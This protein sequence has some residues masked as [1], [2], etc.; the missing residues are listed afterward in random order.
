MTGAGAPGAAGIIKCLLQ[1]ASINLIVADTDEDAIGKHLHPNFIQIPKAAD[2][3]FTEA[4][5]DACKRHQVNVVLPLVTK[6]LFPFAANKNLFESAGI[7]VIVSSQEAIAI[8]NDKS[9]CYKFL[10][11]KGIT[12][13]D[14]RIVN[15]VS[16]FQ[17]AV[18]E[19]GY[20]QKP[21]CFKPSISNGSRGFRIIT[22]DIDESD[23]LFNQKPNNSIC[24]YADITRILSQRPFPEL[25]VSE[26]LPG[27]EFSVDC[28]AN[29][30]EPFLVL[31]RLR[32]KMINGISVK[33]QFIKNE[34]II[35]YCN[36]I[37]QLTGLH[38]N[39]GIQ[40][41]QSASGEFLLL[42][43]NPRVQGTIVAALGAGVNLPLLAV[44][45]EMNIPIQ[46]GEISVVWGTSFSRYWSEIFY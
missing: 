45:Q 20:P 38:G 9:A 35:D 41:K 13:P 10:H 31:P 2:P 26:Y 44:K 24:S 29:Q 18:H 37:I 34:K 30:G 43:I 17:A 5:L 32:K 7:K 16:E 42:E 21:V 22:N 8:A 12:V 15:T 40:V 28:L 23:L 1:D 14:F 39:I 11:Q 33:G 6:E 4:V 46:P 19:L 27:D 36:Q 25:L 3:K